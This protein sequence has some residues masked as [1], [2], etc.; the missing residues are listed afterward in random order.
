LLLTALPNRS[1]IK[2]MWAG[3]YSTVQYGVRYFDLH[4]HMQSYSW[5]ERDQRHKVLLYCL[6][7]DRQHSNQSFII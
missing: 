3:L 6:P 4:V 5:W 1:F 2:S 7:T